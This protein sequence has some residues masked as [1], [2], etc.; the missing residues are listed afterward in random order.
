M[1]EHR[2]TDPA[3]MFHRAPRGWWSRWRYERARG[4]PCLACD[5]YRRRARARID[6]HRLWT[7]RDPIDWGSNENP[8]EAARAARRRSF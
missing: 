5:D 2:T 4:R 6:A 7:G 3:C 1:S 8:D